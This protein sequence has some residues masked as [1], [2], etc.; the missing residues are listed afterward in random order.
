[1]VNYDKNVQD[2]G[3]FSVPRSGALHRGSGDMRL[4]GNR[5]RGA[6]QAI[7]LRVPHLGRGILR[8]FTDATVGPEMKKSIREWAHRRAYTLIFLSVM[9]VITWAVTVLVHYA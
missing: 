6:W 9:F 1:M 7:S 8:S 4:R 3:G 2:P 5:R